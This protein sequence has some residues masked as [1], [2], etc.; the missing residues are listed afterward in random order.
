MARVPDVPQVE[1]RIQQLRIKGILERASANDP[2]FQDALTT[3]RFL[4]DLEENDGD[5]P[6]TLYNDL[7]IMRNAG[8]QGASVL[9]LEYREAVLGG[10]R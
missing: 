6:Q 2:R 10:R 3:R 7:Q 5:Q 4:D 9:W 8:L 1:E